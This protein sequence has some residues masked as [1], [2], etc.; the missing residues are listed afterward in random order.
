MKIGVEIRVVRKQKKVK[1]VDVCRAINISKA[2]L[3]RIETGGRA[4]I[5]DIIEILNYLGYRI[6]LVG[7]DDEVFIKKII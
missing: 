6:V 4:D 2:K 3:S 5:Y 1:S 7:K